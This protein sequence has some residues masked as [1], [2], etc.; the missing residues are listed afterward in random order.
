MVKVPAG[1]LIEQCGW[2]GK[3]IGN[4]ASHKLQSLVI[5]NATGKQQE[6]KFLIF[7]QRSSTLSK[8]SSGLSLNGK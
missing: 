7:P 8:K 1:W 3:Q 2:K 6:K 4:V 5:I